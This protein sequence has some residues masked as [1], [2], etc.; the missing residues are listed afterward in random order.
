MIFLSGLKILRLWRP[1]S[2]RIE[3]RIFIRNEVIFGSDKSSDIYLQDLEGLHARLDFRTSELHF[4]ASGQMI[5]AEPGEIFQIN[6]YVFQWKEF[7]VWRK[8]ILTSAAMIFLGI[9]CLMGITHFHH[10]RE[11]IPSHCSPR[12]EA[13]LR[14]QT[15]DS[16]SPSELSFLNTI[17]EQK[18]SAVE[19]IT[20]HQWVK[21]S[22][23]IHSLE[24]ILR[25]EE[26]QDCSLLHLI[27]SVRLRFSKAIISEH[28]Q[29]ERINE[30][31]D[32]LNR[33]RTLISDVD[34]TRLER[35][36]LRST[37]KIFLTAYRLEE[38][39]PMKADDLLERADR[40]C[41]ILG[42]DPQ[43]YKPKL[44]RRKTNGEND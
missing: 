34:L 9:G 12:A 20:E 39:D 33:L 28:L 2:R 23:E 36:I 24:Q 4:L 8:P 22:A 21:A 3:Q 38:V 19:A 31:A 25:A 35:R 15:D 42:Y 26:S 11:K 14:D 5:H 32:E 7:R 6:G 17:R 18:K 40:V 16:L 10:A 30:A 44:G 37:Q 13:L 29:N 27:S 41:A 43:C 1:S